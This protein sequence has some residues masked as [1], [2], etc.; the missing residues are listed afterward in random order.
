MSYYEYGFI[1]NDPTKLVR[2]VDKIKTR[3]FIEF[4]FYLRSTKSKDWIMSAITAGAINN[5]D[6]ELHAKRFNSLNGYSGY[7]KI[8]KSEI[9]VIETIETM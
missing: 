5:I 4:D 7:G 6:A 9:R 2:M 3:G 8:L 1:L